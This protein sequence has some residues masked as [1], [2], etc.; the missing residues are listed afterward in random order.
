MPHAPSL[1]LPLPLRLPPSPCSA[2][3]KW[4]MAMFD[5]PEA[6]AVGR[7]LMCAGGGLAAV[8]RMQA[9]GYY[10]GTLAYYWLLATPTVGFLF[11]CYLY[12]S[13]NW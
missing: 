2:A 5:V 9:A 7:G 6:I 3:L 13:V 12:I 4:V 11:G 10:L 8:T 1:P